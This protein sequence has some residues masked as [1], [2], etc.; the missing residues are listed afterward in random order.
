MRKRPS[1]AEGGFTLLEVM[2]AL[3]IISISLVVL[4]SA[5]N[6][7]IERSVHASRLTRAA[8]IGQKIMSGLHLSEL[9]EGKWEGKEEAGE[10]LFLWEK[11]VEPSVAEGVLKVTV[12]VGWGDDEVG[13]AFI[14]ETF[15]AV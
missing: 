15:R 8:L 1:A 4:L 10:T 5:Q 13:N 6:A 3:A 7:N 2:V 9:K 12:R 11:R 14:I